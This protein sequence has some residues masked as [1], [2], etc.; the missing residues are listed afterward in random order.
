MVI[1]WRA[2]MSPPFYRATR[3]A[4]GRAAAAPVRLPARRAHR[5]EDEHLLDRSEA[6][7]RSAILTG[8][9]ERPRVGPMR[10]IVATIQPEQDDIVRADLGETVCVQGAPGTGK[11]AVGLHRAAYLLYTHRE[12]LRRGG[13]LVVG[14]N[15]AFLSY[16]AAVLPAL[17]EVDVRQA[18]VEELVARVAGA[19]RGAAPTVATLKGDARMAEVLRNARVRRA[20]AA[21][22]EALVVPRGSRRWRIP[23]YELRR[24]RRE[25]R[26]PRRALR[27]GPGDAAAAARARGAGPDG[28]GRRRRR[29]TGCRTRWPAVR[30]GAQGRRR[31]L[32]GRRPG[33]AGAAAARATPAALAARGRRGPRRRREQ[34]LLLW[35]TPPRGPRSARVVRSPTRCWSTRRPTWSSASRA[36]ATSCSTRRRTSRRCSARRRPPLLDRLGDGARRPRPG[37]HAVGDRRLGRG[38]RATWASRPRTSRSC[39]AASG[40]RP[41]CIDFASRLLPHIAPGVAPAES[42]RENDGAARPGARPAT[43]VAGRGRRG[44]RGARRAGSVGVIVADADVDAAAR[45]SRPAASRTPCSAS[46]DADERGSTVVPATLAKG[47]EYDHVVVVEPAEIVGGRA[48]A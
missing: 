21:P 30:A 45:R 23:A 7:T 20:G 27:R 19:R 46:D 28:G 8:E 4:D 34:A 42:V 24:D 26:A 17:G 6:S 37:H 15:S 10:D 40:C 5:F 11:T 14:P 35:A 3:R 13:V 12:R 29:T 31:A 36:S 41:R 43:C 9:I 22:T 33:A 44:T 25:L 2:A 38:A 18:T 16:I 32:A 48:D 47:L 39:A 1:D